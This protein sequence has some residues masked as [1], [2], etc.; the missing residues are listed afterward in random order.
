MGGGAQGVAGTLSGNKHPWLLSAWLP[1]KAFR[2]LTSFGT[3][4]SV[5][6]SPL[7]F[8]IFPT[9]SSSACNPPLPLPREAGSSWLPGPQL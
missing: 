3:N 6:I 9:L 8:R 5:L 2:W 4:F 7:L 1:S